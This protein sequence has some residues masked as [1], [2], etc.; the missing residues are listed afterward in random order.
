MPVAETPPTGALG[1]LSCTFAIL[2]NFTTELQRV[3]AQLHYAAAAESG[4]P[5]PPSKAAAF[6]CAG[7][8]ETDEV[9]SCLN[10]M[11]RRQEDANGHVLF[12]LNTG[13]SRRAY[14]TLTA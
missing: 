7:G 11:D 13:Q 14:G 9:P 4:E 2:I 1:A 8:A 5:A 3:A 6:A 10:R 12:I